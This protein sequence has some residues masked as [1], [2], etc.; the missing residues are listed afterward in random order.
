MKRG[1]GSVGAAI[2]HRPATSGAPLEGS[3]TGRSPDIDEPTTDQPTTEEP[4]TDQPTTDEPTTDGSVRRPASRLTD[5]LSLSSLAED[6]RETYRFR[7]DEEPHERTKVGVCLS[8]GG[9]RSAAFCLGALQRAQ[10]TG[11]LGEV[12]H[13]SAVSGGGYIAA[14]RAITNTYSPP[15]T[16]ADLQTWAPGSPEAQYL[17]ANSDYLAPGTKGR[18][19]FLLNALWGLLLNLTPLVAASFVAGGVTALVLRPTQPGLEVVGRVGELSFPPA[20]LAVCAVSVAAALVLVGVW[21]RARSANPHRILDKLHLTPV[22]IESL[23]RLAVLAALAVGAAA[24]SVPITVWLARVVLSLASAL[25][26]RQGYSGGG[27]AE[28]PVPTGVEA[29]ALSVSLYAAILVFSA[30][31]VRLARRSRAYKTMLALA[32]FSGPLLLL[33]PGLSMAHHI[34]ADVPAATDYL[35]LAGAA[36][37]CLILSVFAHNGRYSMHLYYRDRLAHVFAVQRDGSGQPTAASPDRPLWLSRIAESAGE[38]ELIICTALNVSDRVV[39][40]GR[41]SASFVFTKRKSGSRLFGEYFDTHELE[42]SGGLG[43]P[44]LTLPSIVAISGAALSPVMGRLTVKPLRFI[45]ALLN[46]RLGV[47]IPNPSPDRA[48][49]RQLREDRRRRQDD[50]RLAGLARKDKQVRPKPNARYPHASAARR[51]F[52][53]LVDGWREPGA[54]YVWREATGSMTLDREFVYITDGGHWDNLGLV[55]LVRR[56]C[57]RVICFDASLDPQDTFE[58][59]RSAIALCRSDL[60]VE[61]DIDPRPLVRNDDGIAETDTVVGSIRYNDQP[62]G[63]LVYSRATIADQTPATLIL[64]A[65]DHD[66]PDHS[67]GDQ[68]FTDDE[69]EAF[70]ALGYD[71]ALRSITELDIPGLRVDQPRPTR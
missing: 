37:L 28:A 51:L 44:P 52:R 49:R 50:E 9:I 35:G 17:R 12:H 20:V 6:T 55:E 21:R 46:I 64:H 67:T 39:P 48:E 38:P 57:S 59:L 22:R 34:L 40:R 23:A 71:T 36:L 7:F 16:M 56:R 43:S 3:P 13:L 63:K 18:L 60:G 70:R 69:F 27:F 25:L 31:A 62:P 53:H 45:L 66:F 14:A 11:F 30:V 68:F 19:W 24:F 2:G 54:L 5:R 29:A 65:S 15:E 26:G 33:I 4:T 41:Q 1:A 8:G 42:R 61:I 47:W 32:G 10:A 58:P